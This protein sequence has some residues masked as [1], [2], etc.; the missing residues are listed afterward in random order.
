MAVHRF[1]HPHPRY[2]I[3]FVVDADAGTFEVLINGCVRKSRDLPQAGATSYVWTNI[4]LEWEE[5]HLLEGWLEPDGAGYAL[6]VTENGEP[7][8]EET[9]AL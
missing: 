4:E 1:T 3:E 5:H 7:I 6:K 9:F 2:R 8:M